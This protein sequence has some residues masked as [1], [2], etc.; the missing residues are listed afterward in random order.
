MNDLK[1]P[2]SG[3]AVG[4]YVCHFTCEEELVLPG[5]AGPLWRGIFG[6]QLRLMSTGTASAPKDLPEWISAREL[7]DYFMVTPPPPDAP[8]MRRYKQVPHPYVFSC[9][10]RNTPRR[11]P[12]G[13]PF[14]VPFRLFGRANA[15]L[16]AVILALARAG[17]AGLGRSRIPARLM[18]VEAEQTDTGTRLPVFTPGERLH[19][20]SP[21]VPSLPPPPRGE[22]LITLLTPL[23]LQQRGRLLRPS[24]FTPAAFLMNLVRRYAMLRLFHGEGE[25]KADYAHLKHLAERAALISPCL[26]WVDQRR[27][28][29]RQKREIPLGGL[30]GN[31]RLDLSGAEDLWPF[32]WWGQE[33]QAGKGS[34]YGMGQ[35]RITPI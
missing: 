3:L 7:Y 18:Q 19:A 33:V 9:E 25:L 11:V 26:Q 21:R 4:R 12:P 14:A 22:V 2:F 10:W 30:L 31:F 15:L 16:P 20:Y 32:L 8:A 24:A 13:Q 23:R 1:D 34:V 17:A 35:Y 6:H 28:S 5:F 27:Y 29:A